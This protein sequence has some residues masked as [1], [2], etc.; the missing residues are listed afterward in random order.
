M[1]I[2]NYYLL[3]EKSKNEPAEIDTVTPP[4]EHPHLPL[5]HDISRSNKEEAET[6][7]TS[8]EQ[9]GIDPAPAPPVRMIHTT[10]PSQQLFC[11]I[12]KQ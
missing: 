9:S 11:H 12:E 10:R 2:V 3:A 5:G 7:R 4:L 8:C 1:Q 6:E